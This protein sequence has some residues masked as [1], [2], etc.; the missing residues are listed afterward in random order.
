MVQI[1]STIQE[2]DEVK[3][4]RWPGEHQRGTTWEFQCP[5]PH[6]LP[7][8]YYFHGYVSRMCREER[9]D[10]TVRRCFFFFTGPWSDE[11]GCAEI[12]RL[13]INE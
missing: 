1:Q 10:G 2:V 5:G 7:C 9:Q 13:S 4:A 8:F 6:F 11:E 3:S 12:I